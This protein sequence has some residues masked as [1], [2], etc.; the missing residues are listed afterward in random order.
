MNQDIPLYTGVKPY[1]ESDNKTEQLISLFDSISDEYDHFNQFASIGLAK[2]WR[3]I[4][5][6]LLRGFN[7][8]NVLD[9]ACG[10]ADMC[11]LIANILKTEAI[12]G[13]D[14]SSEM[15][16]VGRQKIHK[17]GLNRLIQLQPGDSSSISF[18]SESFDIVTVAFGIRNFEKLI[19]S[20]QEMYRVLKP[21]GVLLIVEVNEPQTKMMK[22]LYKRY[23]NFIISLA[24]LLF[25]QNRKSYKYLTNSMAAFPS[26]EKLVNLLEKYQ[27]KLL[28]VKNF[29]FQVCTAYVM[30]K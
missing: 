27:F 9:I 21:G 14:V 18:P 8:E 23:M 5:V 12:I 4:S 20:I 3:R 26:G 1:N 10:T 25:G 17:K 13:I 15:L 6:T 22:S 11:L 29:S 24:V 16:R 2:H 7:S 28:K 19:A 30:Q